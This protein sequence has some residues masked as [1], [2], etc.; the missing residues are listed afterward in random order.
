MCEHCRVSFGNRVSIRQSKIE[1]RRKRGYHDCLHLS[2]T[3][4]GMLFFYCRSLAFVAM[5]S[6]GAVAPVL[7]DELGVGFL[8]DSLLRRVWFGGF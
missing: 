2:H 8:F 1:A 3:G 6:A 7:L 5:V 4:S